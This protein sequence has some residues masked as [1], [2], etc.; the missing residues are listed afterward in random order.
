MSVED[1]FFSTLVKELDFVENFKWEYWKARITEM[2]KDD[3]FDLS[4]GKV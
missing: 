3:T 2:M 1:E 4:P